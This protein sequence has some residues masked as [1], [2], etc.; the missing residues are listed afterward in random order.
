MSDRVVDGLTLRPMTD[1]DL[2]FLEELYGST[3]E[4]EMAQ[5]PWTDEEKARFL[6]FQFNAQHT[7]YQQQFANAQ[8]DVIECEGR[9]VGRLY[10][11]RRDDEIRLVDIA[12]IPAY[13]G[14]GIGTILLKQLR[15]EAGRQSQ[16]LRIHV[17]NQNPAMRL[18]Q[19]L[20]FRKVHDTG[21]Y[22]LMEWSSRSSGG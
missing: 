18:Y 10:V 7:F 11:D 3:R 4:W 8:F 15:A 6:A 1:A 17:E 16:P 9:P 19:R 5:V 12:I 20:G 21:V 2:P 22:H 14:R 13:R